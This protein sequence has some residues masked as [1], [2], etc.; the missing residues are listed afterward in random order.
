MRY[1]ATMDVT[2]A[3]V[4]VETKDFGSK[5]ALRVIPRGEQW[6]TVHRAHQ[7][8]FS[9]KGDREGRRE[10]SVSPCFRAVTRLT[11]YRAL[12]V[13]RFFEGWWGASGKLVGV[14]GNSF[15]RPGYL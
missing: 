6:L 7:V 15:G 3:M 12:Q 9:G 11:V 2:D 8:N 13:R 10:S 14:V 1:L 4:R 5:K